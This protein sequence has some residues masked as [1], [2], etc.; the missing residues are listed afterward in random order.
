MEGN[1]KHQERS[2]KGLRRNQKRPKKE[3]ESFRK[4]EDLKEKTMSMN[5]DLRGNFKGKERNIL[6]GSGK[7]LTRNW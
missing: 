6:D 3:N 7:E 2:W 4:L 5:N 1:Q